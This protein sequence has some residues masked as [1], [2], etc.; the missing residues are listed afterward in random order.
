MDIKT[1]GKSGFLRQPDKSVYS[2]GDFRWTRRAMRWLWAICAKK[3]EEMI[4]IR[5]YHFSGRICEF[6]RQIWLSPARV[7]ERFPDRT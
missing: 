4:R 6:K 3:I 5:R 7:T 2:T 1:A